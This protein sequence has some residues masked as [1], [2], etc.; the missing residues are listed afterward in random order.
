[1]PRAIPMAIICRIAF[2]IKLTIPAATADAMNA[3]RKMALGF[4]PLTHSCSFRYSVSNIRVAF[5]PSWQS[6]RILGTTPVVLG[7]CTHE[8]EHHRHA[9]PEEKGQPEAFPSVLVAD[10]DRRKGSGVRDYRLQRNENS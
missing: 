2:G 3:S 10:L 9:A 4:N 6:G 8:N 7:N 5:R 1:M